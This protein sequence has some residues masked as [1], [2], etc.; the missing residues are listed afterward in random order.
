MAKHNQVL[1]PNVMYVL[2]QILAD[3]LWSRVAFRLRRSMLLRYAYCAYMRTLRHTV[4]ARQNVSDI[5][6]EPI[7]STSTRSEHL[8]TVVM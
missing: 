7:W 6:H 8:S 5:K 3:R 4:F 2:V 1:V